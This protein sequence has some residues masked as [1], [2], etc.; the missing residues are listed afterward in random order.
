MIKHITIRDLNI[1]ELTTT[2][3]PYAIINKSISYFVDLGITFI[4]GVDDLDE[5]DAHDYMLEYLEVN[6]SGQAEFIQ[7]PFMLFHRDNY[8]VKGLMNVHLPIEF[9]E[10]QI[11]KAL[12]KILALFDLSDNDLYWK[13]GEYFDSTGKVN[14]K[15]KMKIK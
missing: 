14:R 2:L 8:P 13:S 7:I 4:P 12:T 15:R 10:D 5:Y 1:D 11:D 6:I 3:H 9:N